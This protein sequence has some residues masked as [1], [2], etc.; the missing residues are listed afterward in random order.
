MINTYVIE[1]D[2][3][4]ILSQWRKDEFFSGEWKWNNWFCVFVRKLSWGLIRYGDIDYSFI[5]NKEN[6][7]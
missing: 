2:E 7:K 5:C 3:F 6:T 4:S 1:H